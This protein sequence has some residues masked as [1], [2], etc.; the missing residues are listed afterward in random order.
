SKIYICWVLI[1]LIITTFAR[2]KR[3]IFIQAFSVIMVC[4]ADIIKGHDVP[5]LN[6]VLGGFYANP[7]DLAFAV[8]LSLPYALAFF[9]LAKNGA[10]KVFW[11]IVMLLMLTVIFLTASRP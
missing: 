3:I 9:V 6:S 1:F 2:L 8:V 5:R 4:I 7:N 10:T 11:F